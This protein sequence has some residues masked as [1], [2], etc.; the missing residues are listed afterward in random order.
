VSDLEITVESVPGQEALLVRAVGS[1]TMRNRRRLRSSVLKCLADCPTAVVVDLSDCRLAELLAA[2]V[3]V[4]VRREAA[5]G[6]GINVL[7]YGASGALAERIKALDPTQPSYETRQQA[8]D[9]VECGPIVPSWRQQRLPV[10][11]ETASLAGC[12]IA[13]A[14]VDWHLPDLVYA[15]R[16]VMFDLVRAAFVCS[17][18]ELRIIVSQRPTGILMS[19]RAQVLAGHWSDCAPDAEPQHRTT[20]I[21]PAQT[22]TYYQTVIGNDHLNWALMSYR[23]G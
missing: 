4:A 18:A 9:A 10:E 6:P 7:V 21:Q 11:P 20:A 16:A 14:C 2:A 23:A 19:I 1:L 17:P 15:A 22:V 3:F 12:L 5:V 8:I 13:D